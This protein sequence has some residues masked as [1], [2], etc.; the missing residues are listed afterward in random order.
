MKRFSKN[1]SGL[2]IVEATFLLPICFLII[3][4]LYYASI[5]LCQKANLQANLQTALIYYKNVESDT[6]VEAKA[7]MDFTNVE[8]VVAGQAGNY[9]DTELLF[10]YRF[11]G[12]KFRQDSFAD[13]FRDISGYMFFDTGDNVKLEMHAQNLV[14]YKKLQATAEQ[15]VSP[16]IS[17]KLVGVPDKTVISATA[18]VAVSDAD[19]FIRNTDLAVDIINQTPVGDALQKCKDAIANVYKNF[20][21]KLNV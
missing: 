20:K 16:A 6:F 15:E 14:I 8:G 13:L 5:F 11:F 17:L 2:A 3:I 19:E 4:A 18:E 12:M 1:E 9:G 7:T 10:P 21:E